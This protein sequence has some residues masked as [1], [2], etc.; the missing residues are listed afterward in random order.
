MT[1]HVSGQN[2]THKTL[3]EG[4]EVISSEFF[5]EVVLSPVEEGEGLG[6]M[7]VLLHTLVTVADRSSG[8]LVHVESICEPIVTIVMAYGANAH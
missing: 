1:S 6:R 4:L 5:E 8:H 2:D 3:S 7:V